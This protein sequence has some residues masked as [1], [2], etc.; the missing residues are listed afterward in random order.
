PTAKPSLSLC[1]YRKFAH[2]H[3]HPLLPHTTS[4]LSPSSL[5]ENQVLAASQML[6]ALAFPVQLAVRNLTTVFNFPAHEVPD[7][8]L[9]RQVSG[10]VGYIWKTCRAMGMGRCL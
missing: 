8:T 5:T 1:K 10:G 6:P 9:A 3:N 2:Q 7:Q 4:H